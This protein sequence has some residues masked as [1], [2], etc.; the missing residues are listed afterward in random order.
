MA[1]RFFT[2]DAQ[3]LLDSFNARIEQKEAAGKIT[4]WERS[5]DKKYYTH[6]ADEWH[7]KAWF[8]PTVYSDRLTFNIIKP[9]NANVSALVYAYYH[10]HLTETF[11]NHFDQLF[12]R[13]VST[14][15]STENDVCSSP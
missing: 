11:L 8:K 5:N 13:S 14:A 12:T 3:K 9:K 6:K 2:D 4:T 15:L 1:A 10:G 7:K